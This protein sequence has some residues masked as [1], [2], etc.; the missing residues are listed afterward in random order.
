MTIVA[1]R[2]FE[3]RLRV[4]TV[5]RKAMKLG[6]LALRA[7]NAG[8]TRPEK[9]RG[10]LGLNREVFA[11]LMLELL[12][13]NWIW[14]NVRLGT[15]VLPPGD[16][17]DGHAPL[18]CVANDT[19]TVELCY[20]SQIDVLIG[21]R[22]LWRTSYP[23]AW[24]VLPLPDLRR[25]DDLS[26]HELRRAA[27]LALPRHLEASDVI[28][29]TWDPGAL[30]IDVVRTG[31]E[32]ANGT[33]SAT[34]RGGA[35]LWTRTNQVALE[36]ALCDIR[37]RV[38]MLW[39]QIDHVY[40]TPQ[41]RSITDDA[42]HF[43]SLADIEGKL[44]QLLPLPAYHVR[45]RSELEALFAEAK[46][47]LQAEASA[48]VFVGCV[49]IRSAVDA[50]IAS[51]ADSIIIS[52]AFASDNGAAWLERSFSQCQKGIVAGISCGMG[53]TLTESEVK[54]VRRL[55]GGLPA[56]TV[57][58]EVIADLSRGACSHAK[59]VV[60]DET[61]VMVTTCNLL[62]APADAAEFEVGVQIEGSG[63][64]E[65]I[66]E[67]ARCL[68]PRAA[69]MI[70]D[71]GD[72]HLGDPASQQYANALST[73]S[74]AIDALKAKESDRGDTSC[75]NVDALERAINDI[76]SISLANPIFVRGVTTLQN[77]I[78]LLDALKSA[79][80]WVLIAGHRLSGFGM[81]TR[82]LDTIRGAL[83]EKIRV[84]VIWGEL[85]DTGVDALKSLKELQ[86][87]YDSRLFFNE[88]PLPW[89]AK[90]ILVDGQSSVVGSYEYLNL[91]ANQNREIS[92][93]SALVHGAEVS[94]HILA[95]L[96][97]WSLLAPERQTVIAVLDGL[98]PL[99]AEQ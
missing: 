42:I 18:I 31:S 10:F 6:K 46:T 94:E 89:H 16:R 9:L 69:E 1:A 85:T 64:R 3:I 99:A 20:L 95:E 7:V 28:D 12:R 59:F 68:S 57:L 17:E 29:V 25:P 41:P 49:A 36:A 48:K 80:R 56:T 72:D 21:R 81:D 35:G 38:P 78:M 22:N 34:P 32:A 52:S 65:L 98:M 45:H 74:A 83:S 50:M 2:A 91:V 27:S 51:A 97:R 82:L 93:F 15:F 19:R 92:E 24:K 39:C 26:N 43:F 5:Q 67:L 63:A 44:Q 11:E 73:I 8:I 23:S 55:H 96:R 84:G 30:E 62:S 47:L 60:A 90:L 13:Q 4:S 76:R 37:D 54:T 14:F 33:F 75:D 87:S 79:Q 86:A 71:G 61:R 77:R 88:T 70:R 53:R 40:S 58:S 66:P